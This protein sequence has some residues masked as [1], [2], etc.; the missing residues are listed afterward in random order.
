M[1]LDRSSN[2]ALLHSI[3]EATA[4]GL[5]VIDLQGS[6][7]TA[8]K[9]FAQM[10]NIPNGLL[11]RGDDSRLLNHVTD[12]LKDPEA[13]IHK[14]RALYNSTETDLD[15]LYFKDKRVFER[16]SSPL[17]ENDKLKGR[18]WSFRDITIK[19]QQEEMLI[20][21]QKMEALG[22]L[23]G[24]IAHDYNNLLAIITGYAAQLTEQLHSDPKLA[25]YSLYIQHA[26]ERGTKLTKKLLAFSRSKTPEATVFNINSLLNDERHMLEKI[27]TARIQLVYNLEDNLWPVLLDSGD[28]EDA[29]INITINA[30]HAMETSGQMTVRT[31][32]ERIGNIDA[33]RMNMDAGDYVLLSVTD[34]GHGMDESIKERIFDPFYTTKGEKGTGLGLSQVYGF[35]ERSGGAIKVYSEPDHGTRFSFYF[36][37]THKVL[38]TAI[39]QQKNT[40]TGAK[41]DEAIL[42]VDDEPALANLAH[43]I[44]TEQGYRVFTANDY[45]Q[46]WEIVNSERIDLMISDAIMPGID[47]YE[48]AAQV[49][50]N[51]PH[52]KIQMTSGFV[53]NRHNNRSDISIQPSILHKPYTSKT[54]LSRVRS[55]LDEK[56]YENSNIV[57]P[58]L[59]LDD[60]PV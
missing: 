48:L 16:Y 18:V 31:S 46:A 10:W 47:G 34:T 53:D 58:A 28:L 17:F 44:L 23:T 15:I 57:E 11:A 60:D 29:I 4:D 5:L 20:R 27:L 54:L 43:D 52:I 9:R 30:M 35:V 37:R 50:R 55:L 12:Q 40:I 56:E 2:E 38:P 13:F 59:T 33:Q 32:N 14:V 8:N 7:L 36:P 26:A 1:T 45:Y 42:I 22:K 3:L 6:V 19:K 39:I 41:G 21:S 49:G 24:G 51:F 25:K